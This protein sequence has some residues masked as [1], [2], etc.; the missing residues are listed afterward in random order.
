MAGLRSARLIRVLLAALTLMVFLVPAASAEDEVIVFPPGL[1]CPGFAVQWTWSP[2]VDTYQEVANRRGDVVHGFALQR[3]DM[4]V[5]NLDSGASITVHTDGSIFH[6]R[7]YPDGS[8]LVTLVGEY[9]VGIY[10]TDTPPGPSTRLYNGRMDFRVDV[11]GN[12]TVLSFRGTE[13][14]LCAPIAD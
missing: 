9:V 6:D 5:T 3:G 4:T 7:F 12:W 10:P 8:A 1:V 13:V 2:E 14:D 11:D